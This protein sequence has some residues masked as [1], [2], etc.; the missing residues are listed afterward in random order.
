M[1]HARAGPGNGC[2]TKRETTASGWDGR[3]RAGAPLPRWYQ[4]LGPVW[5]VLRADLRLRWR[6]ML[7]LAP[8]LGVIGGTVLTAAA[9]ARRTDTAYRRRL[10][11]WSSAASVLVVPNCVGLGGFL[12][13]A[14]PAA[15]LRAE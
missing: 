8:L 14:R 13:Q 15:I 7:G 12:R 9:D 6:T 3:T 4:S 1:S 11:R 2:L 5:I 10:L